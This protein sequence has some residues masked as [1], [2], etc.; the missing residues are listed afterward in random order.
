MFHQQPPGH[1]GS[2]L[3]NSNPNA[4]QFSMLMFHLIF[5]RTDGDNETLTDKT[6][7]TPLDK[8]LEGRFETLFEKAKALQYRGQKTR[9]R[10]GYDG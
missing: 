5:A 2:K 3:K 8:R 4:L 6:L 7:Q 9:E 1:F 10:I